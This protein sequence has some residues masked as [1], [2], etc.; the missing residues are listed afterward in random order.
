M[1]G[2]LVD[3]TADTP[4]TDK[5]N[6]S[7]VFEHDGKTWAVMRYSV[8]NDYW[9]WERTAAGNWTRH[10]DVEVGDRNTDI[11]DVVMDSANNRLYVL[12]NH[13]SSPEITSATY[14]GGTWTLDAN[15]D[16]VSVT[17]IG[18]GSIEQSGLAVARRWSTVTVFVYESSSSSVYVNWSTDHGETWQG[19]T[20]D[21]A[22]TSQIGDDTGEALSSTPQVDA[23]EFSWDDGG[24]SDHYM[25]FAIAESG[26]SDGPLHFL[27]VEEGSAL[28]TIGSYVYEDAGVPTVGFD[29]GIDDHACIVRDTSATNNE[30]FVGTKNKEGS[31]NYVVHRRDTDGNWTVAE[32]TATDGDR[33]CLMFSDDRVF[34]LW[35]NTSSGTVIYCQEYLLASDTFDTEFTLVEEGTDTLLVFESNHDPFELGECIAIGSNSSDS[36]LW[37]GGVVTTAPAAG[38]S[39]L[40]LLGVG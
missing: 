38:T 18:G 12:Q 14:S 31:D 4:T 1:A 8:D 21:I 29:P 40:T 10:T 28:G 15:V 19:G 22:T 33:A 32:T 13:G 36:Q 30:L 5:P 27:R 37:E 26:V 11:P 20:T 39:H 17:G 6:H 3:S 23:C 25:G 34:V 9:I 16:R 35:G 2:S 7:I 24:G